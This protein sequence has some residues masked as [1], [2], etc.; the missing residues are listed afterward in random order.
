MSPLTQVRAFTGVLTLV[1]IGA[2]LKTTFDGE[3]KRLAG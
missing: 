2:L 1:A 3:R